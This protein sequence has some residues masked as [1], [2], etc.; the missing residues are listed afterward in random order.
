[1]PTADGPAL[2]FRAPD[3]T[4]ISDRYGTDAGRILVSD[5][6]HGD[7]VGALDNT[8]GAVVASR[9]Y[10]P[11]GDITG[12]T[13]QFSGGFQDGWTDPD[14]GLVNAHARWYDPSQATFTSRDSLTLK[15][16]PVAATNRYA[17]A[18]ASPVSQSDPSGHCLEDA[19]VIEET[20]F[21]VLAIIAYVATDWWVKVWK[22]RGDHRR[23]VRARR[24]GRHEL[25]R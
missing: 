2:I 8:T 18:N 19:C 14:T 23:P 16:D 3:G 15:P 4:A 12:S 24:R 1:M 21:I 20:V 11:Y 17:Y 13:G 7:R 9:S 5:Q 10:G 25:H 22:G 6:V